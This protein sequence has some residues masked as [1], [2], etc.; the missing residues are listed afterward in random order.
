MQINLMAILVHST[1][2]HKI[3]FIQCISLV[4]GKEGKASYRIPKGNSISY[5]SK[6]IE[7][8]KVDPKSSSKI[9]K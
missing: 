4:S 5:L 1:N 7:G 2:V 6:R 9:F 3:T 8:Y